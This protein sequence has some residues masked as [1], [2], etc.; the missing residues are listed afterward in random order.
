[1]QEDEWFSTVTKTLEDN[2]FRAKIM[3][4]GIDMLSLKGFVK[5][6]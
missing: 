3:K 1:M 4:L 2:D 5:S 6:K